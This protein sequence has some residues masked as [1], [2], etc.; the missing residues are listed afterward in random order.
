MNQQRCKACG[1]LLPI[2]QG[3]GK[4]RQYCNDACQQEAYHERKGYEKRNKLLRNST[5][6]LIYCAGDNKR[7]TRIAHVEQRMPERTH[8]FRSVAAQSHQRQQYIVPLFFP[9]LLESMYLD[10]C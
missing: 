3:R 10:G 5:L 4:H 8:Y 1:K 6:D 7:L 2:Q 9:S